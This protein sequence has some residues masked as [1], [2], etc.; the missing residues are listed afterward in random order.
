M[1]S[2]L[3]LPY[4]V[5]RPENLAGDIFHTIPEYRWPNEGYHTGAGKKKV[6]Y[7]DLTLPQ[8]PVGQLSNIFHMKDPIT[9]KHALLQVILAMKYATSLPRSHRMAGH[10]PMVN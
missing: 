5:G 1:R 4:K 7:D 2:R 8:W 9:A 6:A 10:H 3:G